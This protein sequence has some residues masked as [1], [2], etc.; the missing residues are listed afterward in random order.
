MHFTTIALII[1][2]FQ[3]ERKLEWKMDDIDDL[4][5]RYFDSVSASEKSISFLD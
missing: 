4:K 5:V 1:W 2:H 3:F